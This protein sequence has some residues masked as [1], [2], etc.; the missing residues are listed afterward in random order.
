MPLQADTS[1][2]TLRAYTAR[3]AAKSARTRSR[4]W[5]RRS[6]EEED[7][8]RGLG[9]LRCDRSFTLRRCV[10]RGGVRGVCGAKVRPTAKR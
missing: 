1:P 2:A 4:A 6:I 3:G 9:E 5:A 7:N 8:T 10:R